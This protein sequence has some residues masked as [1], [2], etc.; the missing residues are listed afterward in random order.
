M[1]SLQ[2]PEGSQ[3]EDI[4]VFD[5]IELRSTDENISICIAGDMNAR[6]ASLA[7]CIN[8]VDIDFSIEDNL[9]NGML[10]VENVSLEDDILKQRV[11]NIKQTWIRI[12]SAL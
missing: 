12:D 3:Y 8:D 2:P 6:T 4:E 10:N 11:S 1:F 9:K 7:D 5:L